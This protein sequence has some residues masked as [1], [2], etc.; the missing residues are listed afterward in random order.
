[1]D[2]QKGTALLYSHSYRLARR[3]RSAWFPANSPI[4]QAPATICRKNWVETMNIKQF[5][6]FTP[7]NQ[8][9][10][11]GKDYLPTIISQGGELFKLLGV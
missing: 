6:M 2:K 1:M 3:A 5:T 11:K 10:P 9:S 4:S 7:E 8:P